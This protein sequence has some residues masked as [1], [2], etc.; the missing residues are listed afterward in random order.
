[1]KKL[2]KDI[3]NARK[4]LREVENRLQSLLELKETVQTE[5]I[6]PDLRNVTV[7]GAYLQ[8]VRLALAKVLKDQVEGEQRIKTKDG[9]ALFEAELKLATRSKLDAYRWLT[10]DAGIMFKLVDEKKKRYEANF[11]EKKVIYSKL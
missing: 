9:R 8:G 5:E 3:E 4:S 11:Y 7:Y 2:E 6:Q 10:E 1:M